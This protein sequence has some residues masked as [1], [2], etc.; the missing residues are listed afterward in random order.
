MSFPINYKQRVADQ[1]DLSTDE[2][3]ELLKRM[4]GH[5]KKHGISHKEIARSFFILNNIKIRKEQQR[6]K[7]CVPVLGFKHKGI[8]LYRVEFVKKYNKGISCE[9]IYKD[10]RLKKD[11]PSLATVKR[12]IKAYKEWRSKNV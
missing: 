6:I 4:H 10:I 7:Q 3:N 11:A 5:F 2:V 8:E 1:F 9:Q 12:Y